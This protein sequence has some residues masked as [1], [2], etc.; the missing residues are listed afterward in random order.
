ML[1]VA[2]LGLLSG[3]PAAFVLGGLSVLFAAVGW[4]FGVFDPIVMS[5]VPLRIFGLMGNQTLLAIP[6]FIFMGAV[7]E[8]ADLARGLLLAIAKAVGNRPGGLG[9]AVVVC[10]GLMAASSGVAGAS[11]MSIGMAALPMMLKAGYDQ[12]IAAGSIAAA[13][14]LGQ[15]IPPSIAL[16]IL[17]D[18]ISA[19][20]Q[21]TQLA[22]GNFAPDPVSAV[23]LFAGAMLP[24]I[25]LTGCYAL[26][27]GLGALIHPDRQPALAIEGAGHWLIE[28]LPLGLLILAVLGAIFFGLAAPSEGA[29][30]GA[31]GALVLSIVY[32]RFSMEMLLEAGYRTVTMTG[33][34]FMLIVG[35]SMFS[36]VFREIGGAELVEQAIA[37]LPGGVPAA[38]FFGMAIVFVLGFFLEFLEIVLLI[39]PLLAAPLLYMGV[40]PI[41]LA[42]MLAINLQTSF[43]TPPLG[44]ALFY[45]RGIAPEEVSTA[46]IYRGAAPFVAVQLAV[47]AIVA[48][49]PPLATYLPGLIER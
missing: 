28:A 12:K 4:A 26:W 24:G 45:L 36:L 37:G 10:G 3:Y 18:T 35:A 14:T 41:W 32:R 47:L 17:A 25:L 38:L 19:V 40:D 11:I 42:I 21:E 22:L 43:L 7:L 15:L 33:M 39:V 49:F 46:S 5:G 31:V 29:T 20:H 8:R 27:L 30:L 1:P 13:G 48:A 23:D 2:C 34:I 6:F 16:V 44:V 9:L